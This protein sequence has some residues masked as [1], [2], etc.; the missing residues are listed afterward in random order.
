MFKYFLLVALVIAAVSAQNATSCT[1]AENRSNC[2]K[3]L[4]LNN[5]C[6]FCSSLGCM[7]NAQAKHEACIASDGSETSAVSACPDPCYN[8]DNNG[9]TECLSS[10]CGFCLTSGTCMTG[11]ASGP[12]YKS[13]GSWRYRASESALSV[14]Q[15]CTA[16]QTCSAITNC[17]SCVSVAQSA[18]TPCVWC[19]ATG[20]SSCVAGNTCPSGATAMTSC[21][22]PDTSDACSITAGVVSFVGFMAALGL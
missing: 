13:C 7:E 18:T 17:N 12:S 1:A 5:A 3:C 15:T 22:S 9:C 10:S 2:F 21:P 20:G 11:S 6:F 8:P 19:G 16:Y 4:S 14:P